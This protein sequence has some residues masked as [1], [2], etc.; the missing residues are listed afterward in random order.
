MSL[1]SIRVLLLITVSLASHFSF[2]QN[3][4]LWKIDHP[5]KE[6]SSYIFGT[7]HIIPKDRFKPSNTLDSIIK[8]GGKVV[9]EIKLD[10]SIEEQFNLATSMV[11]EK[12]G[13]LADHLSKEKMDRLKRVLID[14]LKFEES[15]LSNQYFNLKPMFM[16]GIL[17]RELIGDV[18]SYDAWVGEKATEY[19][20]EKDALESVY[21]QIGFIDS[22]PMET[23]LSWLDDLN[24]NMLDDYLDMLSVYENGNLDSL[25][26]M[27]M[28]DPNTTADFQLR[29][30]RNKNWISKMLRQM[31]AGSVLFA[32]GALHLPGNDG[33][34]ELLRQE[35][36]LTKVVDQ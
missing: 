25:L 34:L 30:V 24:S 32:V 16:T 15:K 9:T 12:R 2:A 20:K 27:S 22:I 26:V 19:G 11:F 33:L 6:H 13:S 31:Q 21:N 23:Q 36:Y 18:E 1:S 28:A 7:M 10:L 3:G 5:K 29:S 35:G 4:V 14:T 17:L 8:N